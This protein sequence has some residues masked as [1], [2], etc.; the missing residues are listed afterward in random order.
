MNFCIRQLDKFKR[1]LLFGSGR[2]TRILDDDSIAGFRDPYN[3]KRDF[4]ETPRFTPSVKTHSASRRHLASICALA[5]LCIAPLP[6]AEA[7][8]QNVIAISVDGLRGDYLQTIIDTTP[9]SFPN[10]IRLHE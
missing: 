4:L 6:K 8:I 3:S 1:A 9:A 5:A 2:G 10:I 7:A